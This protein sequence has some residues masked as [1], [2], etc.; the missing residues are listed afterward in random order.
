M[1][2]TGLLE[3]MAA[4]ERAEL[5]FAAHPGSPS[6]VRRPQLSLRSG[7][8]VAL[9]GL[10]VQE[11]IVG[12]GATVETALGAFDDQYMA[13]LRPPG[14]RRVVGNPIQSKRSEA[15]ARGSPCGKRVRWSG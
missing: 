13:F 1:K 4:N 9:L 6:A 7:R 14:E 12:I 15:C 5:Y 3:A 10:N 8:W 11:G 2:H